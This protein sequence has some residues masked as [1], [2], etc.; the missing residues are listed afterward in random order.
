MDWGPE[1][2]QRPLMGVREVEEAT[3][4]TAGGSWGE[5]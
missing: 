1:Y 4:I 2:K 5:D 3:G